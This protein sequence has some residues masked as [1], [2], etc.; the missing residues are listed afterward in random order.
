MAI[1]VNDHAKLQICVL[2][3]NSIAHASKIHELVD[4]VNRFRGTVNIK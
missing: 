2:S 1:F 4:P 3:F